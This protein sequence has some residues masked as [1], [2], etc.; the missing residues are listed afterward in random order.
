[1]TK[2]VQKFLRLC[3]REQRDLKKYDMYSGFVHY[4]ESK[5]K[6]IGDKL[7]RTRININGLEEFLTE[8]EKEEIEQYFQCEMF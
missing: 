4:N 5:M 1:M 2:N 3:E 7:E 6:K 8:E